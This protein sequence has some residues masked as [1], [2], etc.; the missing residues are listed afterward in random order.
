[1]EVLALIPARSGSKGIPH[2]NIATFRGK[3]LLAHSISQAK[4]SSL[5][6]RVIVSTDS[7][8]YA[9]ISS[10]YGAEV[11]FLR[12]PEI[13]GDFSTDLEA[14]VHARRLGG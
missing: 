7:S 4:Q 5:V 10:R 14:F 2:K 13:S 9:D 8:L 12:P 6:T 11:P 1:M 3:P